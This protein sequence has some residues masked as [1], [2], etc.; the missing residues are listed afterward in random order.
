MVLCAV[1]ETQCWRKGR[2]MKSTFLQCLVVWGMAFCVFTFGC[3]T[4]SSR[5]QEDEYERTMF[6][7][8]TAMQLSDF[9]NVCKFFDPAVVKRGECLASYDNLK[10]V[11]YEVQDIRFSEDKQEATHSVVVD[12]HF[13]DRVVV[14]KIQ[15]EQVWQ[16]HKETK[17][18]MLQSKPPVFK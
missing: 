1:I 14:K 4:L 5:Y 13:Q 6:D 2:V 15:F 12:Y 3:S 18:W 10:I 8:D 9:N 7:Y 11:E 16:Y 17:T